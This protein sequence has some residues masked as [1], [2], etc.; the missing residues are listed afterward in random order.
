MW[1]IEAIMPRASV[2][3][4]ARN[5]HMS[6]ADLQ[7]IAANVDTV[8]IVQAMD[9][10]NARRLEREV[11]LVTES[12]AAPVIVL[13]KADLVADP[14]SVIAQLSEVGPG[15]A[16][17]HASGLTG[18][19]VAQLAE[20]GAGGK[21]LAFIGASGVGKST[22]VNWLL[23]REVQPTQPVRRDASAAATQRAPGASS[24]SPAAAR[25]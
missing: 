2:I 3:P 13:S 22:L 12:G 17:L 18:D 6:I 7:V 14:G 25:S 16:V 15:T 20:Y 11:A 24:L 19:G 8:F 9:N 23:G 4:R 21:T 1:G 5:A 10:P